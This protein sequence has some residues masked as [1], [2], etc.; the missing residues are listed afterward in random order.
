[1]SLAA[2]ICFN[3]IPIREERTVA[4]RRPTRLDSRQLPLTATNLLL[5]ALT[6]ERLIVVA[7][8][9][10]ETVGPSGRPIKAASHCVC[11]WLAGARL[12]A[13]INQVAKYNR[14][15]FGRAPLHLARELAK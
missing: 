4:P 5:P 15:Q 12:L 11:W 2:I 10:T 6:S 9:G 7:A 3:Y 8:N 13:H 14:S 1:M